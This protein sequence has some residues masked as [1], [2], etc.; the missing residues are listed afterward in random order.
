MV[1]VYL[2]SSATP[3]AP[4]AL[5]PDGDAAQRF[6]DHNFRWYDSEPVLMRD[7]LV[8]VTPRE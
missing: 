8:T 5:L 6:V 1:A 3:E 4:V 2:T 7:V